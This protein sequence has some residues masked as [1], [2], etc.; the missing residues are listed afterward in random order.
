MMRNA[1]RKRTFLTGLSICLAGFLFA[2]AAHAQDGDK[3]PLAIVV[4]PSATVENLTM[5]ELRRIFLAEQQHWQ[6]NSRIIL[7]MRAPAAYERDFVL[8]RIY[9]MSE[10]QFRRYWIAK[11][12]R[13]E[14]ASGPKVV[15]STNMARE[16]VTVI[17]GSITFVLSSDA[18]SDEKVIKIDGKLPGDPAYPLK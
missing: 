4:H 7:L 13:A 5:A 11:M 1:A 10:D 18:G 8:D 3:G 17:P 16:L 6:D 2:V 9:K 14:V 12:F 15:F